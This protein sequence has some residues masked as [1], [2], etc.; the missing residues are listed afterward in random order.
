MQKWNN[1]KAHRFIDEPLY[2]VSSFKMANL[3]GE[4]IQVSLWS[5]GLNWTSF[6]VDSVK[7]KMN[8]L[9]KKVDISNNWYKS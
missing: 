2:R 8:S 6:D 1:Y 5:K 9:N 4:L 7:N 3:Q